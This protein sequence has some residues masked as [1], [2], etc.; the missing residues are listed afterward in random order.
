MSVSSTAGVVSATAVTES[1]TLGTSLPTLTLRTVSPDP[2]DMIRNIA[3]L[4]RM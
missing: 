3:K 2:S 4:A 1:M